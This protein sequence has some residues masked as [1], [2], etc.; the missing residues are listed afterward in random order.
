MNCCEV[1]AN[2]YYYAYYNE[3]GKKVRTS[4][5]DGVYNSHNYESAVAP[6]PVKRRSSA[7]NSHKN[8]QAAKQLTGSRFTRN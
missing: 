6:V 5:G 3:S 2:E 7:S 1:E 8:A 4:D